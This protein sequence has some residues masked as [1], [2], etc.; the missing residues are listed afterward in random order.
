MS[1]LLGPSGR[2]T[3]GSCTAF[4]RVGDCWALHDDILSIGACNPTPLVCCRKPATSPYGSLVRCWED[5][6]AQKIALLAGVEERLTLLLS[7]G[8]LGKMWRRKP[9]RN[10]S[11]A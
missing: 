11:A 9:D 1:V 6:V 2:A 8:R 10:L 7:S 4:R 5:C 3:L